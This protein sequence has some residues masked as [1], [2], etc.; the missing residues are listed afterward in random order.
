MYTTLKDQLKIPS[1]IVDVPT[2]RN[3]FTWR[4]PKKIKSEAGCSSQ[5][6]TNNQ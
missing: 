1:E 5:N 4:P 3:R 6:A 2:I